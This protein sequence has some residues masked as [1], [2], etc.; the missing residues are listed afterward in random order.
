MVLN[1]LQQVNNAGILSSLKSQIIIL[2]IIQ[3]NFNLDSYNVI[4]PS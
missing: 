4:Y 2:N 3:P 1:L